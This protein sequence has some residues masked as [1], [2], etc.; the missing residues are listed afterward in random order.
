[1]K[2]GI[3]LSIILILALAMNNGCKILDVTED[4][5]FEQELIAF[6]E[7]AEFYSMDLLAADS[8]SSV[9]DDYGDK[10]KKIEVKEVTYQITSVGDSCE[11]TKINSATLTVADENGAGEETIGTVENQ[12]IACLPI[13]IPMPLNQAGIDRFENLIKNSPHRA[14]I[15]FYGSAD[16]APVDFT[17]ELKITVKMTANP[18]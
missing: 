12:D 6:S 5:T 3:F 17:V 16:G 2:K 10:I 18:L 7:T 8:L 11:A 4:I 14:L 1:M 9:I 15:K 13:P